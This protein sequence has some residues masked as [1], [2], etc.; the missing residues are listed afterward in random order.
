MFNFYNNALKINNNNNNNNNKDTNNEP[1]QLYNRNIIYLELLIIKLEK[2]D[3][4]IKH[5]IP[6]KDFYDFSDEDYLKIENKYKISIRYLK[7]YN[8]YEFL[9]EPSKIFKLKLLIE[10][11][12]SCDKIFNKKN[13]PKMFL[14][15]ELLYLDQV[16]V[17]LLGF[18]HVDLIYEYISECKNFDLHK[19]IYCLEDNDDIKSHLNVNKY[20]YTF[21]EIIDDNYDF[22]YIFFSNYSSKFYKTNINPRSDYKIIGNYTI[23]IKECLHLDPKYCLQA[24][25]YHKCPIEVINTPYKTIKIN[26]KDIDIYYENNIFVKGA[27]K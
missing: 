18:S 10:D 5:I 20:T 19:F 14:D 9:L 22:G 4:Y 24:S 2:Y 16:N 6:Y 13:E 8:I 27:K 3:N 25:N 15:Q 12:L 1:K 11:N 17:K 23:T 26:P 21:F 7:R